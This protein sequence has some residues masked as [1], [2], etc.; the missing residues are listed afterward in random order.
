MARR[1]RELMKR[2]A[3][4]L[5]PEQREQAGRILVDRLIELAVQLIA[6]SLG[7]RH[8]HLLGKFPDDNVRHWVGLAKKEASL[9]MSA[10]G[11]TGGLWAKR[12]KV[13]PIHDRAH[14]VNAFH[15]IER[16]ANSGAWVWTFRHGRQ[17]K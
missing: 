12:C 10:Q 13:E 9:S 15:Y 3:V 16:H 4:L 14:Q 1:S 5:S 2:D 8:F 7:Q 6:L 11:L 17:W